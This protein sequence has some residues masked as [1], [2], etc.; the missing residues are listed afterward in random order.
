MKERLPTLFFLLFY[1]AHLLGV[2]GFVSFFEWGSKRPL[3][4][5]D[6]ALRTA[7]FYD[8]RTLFKTT[9][10]LWGYS[11]YHL[12]GYPYALFGISSKG[13]QILSLLFPFVNPAE[14]LKRYILIGILIFPFL[15]MGS[16]KI[17]RLSL[18]SIAIS[19][20]ISIL[21][22]WKYPNVSSVRWG[23]ISYFLASPFTLLA[24]AFFYQFVKEKH[25][26]SFFLFWFFGSISFLIHS[27]ALVLLLPPILITLLCS[28]KKKP[29]RPFVLGGLGLL[30]IVT[31]NLFWILPFLRYH[32][33]LNV[34][35]AEPAFFENVSL[36]SWYFQKDLSRIV[37]L[38]LGLCGIWK[39]SRERNGIALPFA[40]STIWLISLVFFLKRPPS[41]LL[42]RFRYDWPLTLFLSLPA[43]VFIAEKGK[44]FSN[45]VLYGL[46][47]LALVT[48][49][50][51]RYTFCLS[52][53]FLKEK[54]LATSYP[55]PTSLRPPEMDVLLAWVQ[56]NKDEEGR[57]LMEDTHHPHHI[58]WGNHLPAIL[59]LL[60]GRE[61]VTPPLPEVSLPV[62]TIGLTDGTLFGKPIEQFSPS[63]FQEYTDRYNIRWMI[64]FSPATKQYLK[65]FPK[66]YLREDTVIGHFSFYEINRPSNFFLK[67][68]GEVSAEFN[69]IS[70]K[71]VKAESG[72]V[73][74]KYH[75]FPMLRTVPERKVERI[76]YG[77]DPVGFIKIQNP[78]EEI[79]IVL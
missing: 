17:L 76:D 53:L 62:A 79:E 57:L 60:T 34:K 48:S 20:A 49:D 32:S 39:W 47:L 51:S 72:E 41:L 12:A 18:S 52:R 33:M 74:L 8:A 65:G 10:S 55:L 59:P 42:Q 35:I 19:G 13:E 11:P 68:S 63:A 4:T 6:Y 28:L 36:R 26:R 70:L 27:V 50:A 7:L 64:C 73:V 61:V 5:D 46:I 21:F 58:Y 75:W 1:L 45:L 78:P 44:R 15:I 67:G 77:G 16:A 25:L 30:G 23:S 37:L 24:L 14:L 54:T 31:I 38:L 2:S 69:R 56:K 22:F 43:S 71:N 29:K 40:V 9:R 3:L 66:S